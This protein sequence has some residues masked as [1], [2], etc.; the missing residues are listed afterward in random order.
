MAFDLLQSTARSWGLQFDETQLNCFERYAAELRDWNERVN[1]T[2]V[3]DLEEIERRHFLDSLTC[4]FAW[5]GPP[6]D[7]LVDIGA[8]A[9]F[10]GV[11][12][13]ILWPEVRLTL[14]ESIGKKAAFLRH[15]VDVLQLRDVEVITGRAEEI[16]RDPAHRERYDLAV[17]R[18]VAALNVLAEY[19]LP[20]VRVGGMFLAPKGSDIEE[21]LKAGRRAFGQLGGSLHEVYDVEIPGLPPR[22]LVAVEKLRPTSPTFPRRPG[23]PAKKPL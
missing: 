23:I 5:Q 10:P 20:L 9:G 14:V 12:L 22:V 15:L 21:E 16:G 2:A 6:P 7:S 11:P 3:T 8:G 19:C 4:A 1:L 13:K 17:A 18:A